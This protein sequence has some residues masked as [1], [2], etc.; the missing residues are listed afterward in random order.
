MKKFVSILLCMALILS[1][2]ACQ[3][4]TGEAAATETAAATEPT[5]AEA[6]SEPAAEA[7]AAETSD[8][9]SV[10]L[11]L[12]GVIT[13]ESWNYTAY[14]GL[15]QLKDEGYNVSYVENTDTSNCEAVAMNYVS[16]GYNLVI[17]HGSQFGD[18]MIRVAESNPNNYFFVYGK[19]PVDNYPANIGFVDTAVYTATYACGY[20]AAKMSQSGVIGYIG[21]TESAGQLSMKNGYTQGAKAANPDISVLTI[22]TGNTDDTALGKES[23]LS[24]IDQK[25]DVIM[26]AADTT[27]LGVIEACVEKGVY[28]IGYGSDQHDLAPDQMLTSVV[29]IV[30]PVIASQVDRIKDGTFGGVYKPGLGV[31]VELAAL[32]ELI[33]ADV[34][35]E[36]NGIVSSIQDGTTVVQESF[37]K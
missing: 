31:G 12:P 14:Q 26:H 35:S 24:M 5:A 25:A 6:T 21:G 2:V 37:E 33:P 17:A 19:A 15:M 4:G 3:A 18:S 1:F 20:L 13:D 32:S 27:G 30:P 29:E 7:T 8:A 23:A 9:L 10:A 22:M 34:A 11:I 36:V 16:E 28:V